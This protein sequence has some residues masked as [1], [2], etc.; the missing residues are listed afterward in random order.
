M[1]EGRRYFISLFIAPQTLSC[2][3]R[4]KDLHNPPL[5]VTMR[6]TEMRKRFPSWAGENHRVRTGSVFD[7]TNDHRQRRNTCETQIYRCLKSTGNRLKSTEKHYKSPEK[8]FSNCL[9]PRCRR[10][11]SCHSDQ[12][13]ADFVS[14]ATTFYL[15]VIAHSLRRSSF[16]N[17]T[18][19]AGLRF[20][21]AKLCDSGLLAAFSTE[22]I[23]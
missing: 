5:R 7:H 3:L 16:P 20:G 9:G 14:F 15:K 10:F 19:C 4:R 6:Q 22:K 8:I 23:K 18:R 12:V 11:E 13:V 17:R 2:A 21:F 1:A